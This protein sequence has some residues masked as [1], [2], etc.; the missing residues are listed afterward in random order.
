MLQQ[1]Y[2]IIYVMI[3]WRRRTLLLFSRVD[4]KL[5]F[6]ILFFSRTVWLFLGY[7][8]INDI[9]LQYAACIIH[10]DHLCIFMSLTFFYNCFFICTCTSKKALYKY[11]LSLFC[12][13]RTCH[14]IK[15]KRL[16]VSTVF[17]VKFWLLTIVCHSYINPLWTCKDREDV[18]T[19]SEVETSD[20]LEDLE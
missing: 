10:F 3:V 12:V 11:V 4:W 15:W 9:S 18:H 20:L 14:Y 2:G 19:N 16:E 6:L 5:I 7:H 1:C 17:F 13:F 8:Y